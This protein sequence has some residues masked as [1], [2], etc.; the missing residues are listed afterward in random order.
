M[1]WRTLMRSQQSVRDFKV[2]STFKL[3]LLQAI[4]LGLLV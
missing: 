1:E 3:M 4:I 2:F